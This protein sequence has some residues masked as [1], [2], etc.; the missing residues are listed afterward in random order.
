MLN[1]NIITRIKE[2]NNPAGH[3]HSIRMINQQ[4]ETGTKNLI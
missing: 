3:G 1:R 2:L 4:L